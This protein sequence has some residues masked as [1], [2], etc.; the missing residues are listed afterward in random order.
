[1][2]QR[3]D[4]ALAVLLLATI[5]L[6]FIGLLA[7]AGFTVVA[8]RR[9]RALGMIGAIGATD[10]Q[11]RR[12]M[13]ANGAGVGAT[14]GLLGALLGL[15]V[16]FALRPA[17]E[18]LVG[19]HIDSARIPWWAVI[20]AA[21]LAVVTALAASWWPA[22]SAARMP[23]VAALSGR[24]SPPRP[25]HRFALLGTGLAAAGFLLLVLAHARH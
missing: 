10:R 23:I 3:R 21:G 13:L 8:H 20:A 2:R 6:T 16:W 5:G 17:F 19:H 9:L 15:T 7:V 4:Q 25:A 18:H 22:R 1:A 12:V 14:G 11:I 24:P